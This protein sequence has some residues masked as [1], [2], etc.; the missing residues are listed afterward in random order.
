MEKANVLLIFKKGSK[1]E[2]NNYRPISLRS[3]L[4]KVLG[5]LIRATVK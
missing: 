5:S 1:I 2:A 4:V 3:Q